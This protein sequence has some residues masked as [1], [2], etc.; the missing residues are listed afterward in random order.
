M[1]RQ[2]GFILEFAPV[3][4]PFPNILICRY[5]NRICGSFFSENKII[6][7]GDDS[8]LNIPIASSIGLNFSY[9]ILFFLAIQV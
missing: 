6:G 1:E 8:R 2:F 3:F 4:S 5:R 7:D 9:K